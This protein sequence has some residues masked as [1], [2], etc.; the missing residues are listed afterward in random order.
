MKSVIL[1]GGLGTRLR[2]ETEFL[3]KP[4]VPIG[5]KPILWHIMKTYAFYEHTDFVVCTGYKSDVIRD[6]FLNYQ[7]KNLDF[8]VNLGSINPP[9]FYEEI[10]E[11][12][13]NVTISDTGL[14]TFT[15]G[16]IK[17]IQ[18]YVNGQTFFC[19]YG[20]GLADL[21]LDKL[22]KFHNAHGKIATVTVVKP[23]S[24]FGV[25][26]IQKNNL[27]EKFKEKP[28]ADGWINVGFFVFNKEIF[29][30]LDPDSVLEESP[31]TKLAEAG[32]LMAY[33]HEGFWQSMDTYREML[34]LNALWNDEKAPW[35][36]WK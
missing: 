15:G 2:E 5:D 23:T 14:S 1:A 12:D 26:E 10:S 11:K 36:I 35:K 17:K 9:K 32:E 7:S 19:T 13:W 22:L 29:N 25:V 16:R 27:V 6:F 3:P 28:Q 21:D 24:R 33:K 34:M 18:K 31:L 8:T 30:Y 20:D 4:M